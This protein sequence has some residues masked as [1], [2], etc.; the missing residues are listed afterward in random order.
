MIQAT[1]AIPLTFGMAVLSQ[2]NLAAQSTP[3]Y[4]ILQGSAFSL[5]VW[6]VVAQH[7]KSKTEKAADLADRQSERKLF[8]GT[9]DNMAERHDGWEKQRHEDSENLH[10][11]LNKL[12]VTC[13]KTH[14]AIDLSRPGDR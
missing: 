14:A 10:R 1:V 2:T 3:F 4:W 7:R 5:V 6:M 13:A 8:V 11:S 9:L 12:A